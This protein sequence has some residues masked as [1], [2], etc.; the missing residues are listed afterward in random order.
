MKAH[1]HTVKENR[2]REV[3]L[4]RRKKVRVW[5]LEIPPPLLFTP[6]PSLFGLHVLF[7][8][9]QVSK[10]DG[11]ECH[12]FLLSV[13]RKLLKKFDVLFGHTSGVTVLLEVVCFYLL[14]R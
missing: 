14:L 12:L 8:C 6:P 4:S 5:L 1:K 11:S 7:S 9:M 13:L 2:A 10:A 3:I